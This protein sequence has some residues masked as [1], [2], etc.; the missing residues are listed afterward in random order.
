MTG[1]SSMSRGC[2][3]RWDIRG[4][5]KR[6][7]AGGEP[8][9]G[10]G[11]SRDQGSK[12]GIESGHGVQRELLPAGDEFGSGQEGGGSCGCAGE[13]MVSATGDERYVP[14]GVRGRQSIGKEGTESGGAGTGEGAP[15]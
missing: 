13:C 1:A 4:A 15:G 10:C 14:G 3:R 5:F 2:S 7:A 11:V 8:G 6:P 9:A 12:P